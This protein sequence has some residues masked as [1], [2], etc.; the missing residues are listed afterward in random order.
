MTADPSASR[1]SLAPL[2]VQLALLLAGLGAIALAPPARGAMLL[3]PLTGQARADLP[4]L[5]I[6]RGALLL[7]QGPLSGSLVVRGDRARLGATL[8]RRG[9]LSV[10]A[11]EI[12]CGRVVAQG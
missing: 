12:F 8:L 2:L 9:I 4:G 7:G 10:A 3:V 5:A 11:P 6:G 1:T